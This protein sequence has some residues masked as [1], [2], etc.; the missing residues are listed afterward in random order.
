MAYHFDTWRLIW[1]ATCTV[2]KLE[3]TLLTFKW[4]V[5]NKINSYLKLS[6]FFLLLLLFLSLRFT[7]YLIYFSSTPS[8]PSL[9]NWRSLSPPFILSS[10]FS[11]SFS[12][13]CSLSLPLYVFGFCNSLLVLLAYYTIERGDF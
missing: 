7:N 8:L 3:P 12:N 13:A 9:S 4:N 11:F 5:L 1:N 2:L 6:F 10:L